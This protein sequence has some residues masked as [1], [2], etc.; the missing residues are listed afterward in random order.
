MARSLGNQDSGFLLAWVW[1]LDCTVCHIIH[2]SGGWPAPSSHHGPSTPSQLSLHSLRLFSVE[3]CLFNTIGAATTWKPIQVPNPL[4]TNS[5]VLHIHRLGP[6]RPE[7]LWAWGSWPV[8]QDQEQ[9]TCRSLR[10]QSE[11]TCQWRAVW[12]YTNSGGGEQRLGEEKEVDYHSWIPLG[13]GAYK[14]G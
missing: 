5:F 6:R 12:G 13:S 2:P 10:W 3:L 1:F 8:L 7:R 9:S 14:G 4:P 11:V